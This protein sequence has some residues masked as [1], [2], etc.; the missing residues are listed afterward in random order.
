M[1]D[2]P[3]CPAGK[4]RD[5]GRLYLL[6]ILLLGAALRWHLALTGGQYFFNDEGRF[7]RGFQ[8]YMA[9]RS[10]NSSALR[11]AFNHADHTAFTA[12]STVT[13]AVQHLLAR[14]FTPWG[15][16]D[17][18]PEFYSFSIGYAA[19]VLSLAGVI[20]AW[21]VYQIAL[22]AGASQREALWACLLASVANT[23]VMYGR[24]L[25]GY[26][27][28]LVI[29]LWALLLVLGG[30]GFR[31]CLVAGVLVGLSYHVY[32][33]YW[34]FTPLLAAF[35]LLRGSNRSAGLREAA[36]FCFS[37]VA[38]IL[39]GYG[40]GC[41]LYGAEFL[42]FA[43]TFSGTV[44]QGVFAEG[45]S[46][47]WEFLTHAESYL[48]LAVLVVIV[49]AVVRQKVWRPEHRRARLWGG[50][51]LTSYLLLVIA[52]CGLHTFVVYARTVKPFIP[53]LALLGG[54]ALC[55][56][57]PRRWTWSAAAAILLLAA[58]NVAPHF[59][60]VFPREFE[61]AVMKAVG[62]PKRTLTVSGSLYIPVAQAVTAPRF[63][64]VNSQHLYPIRDAEPCPPGL[65]VAR[66]PHPLAYLPFQYE[67]HSPAMREFLRHADIDM[68]LLRLAD[69][70]RVPDD[71]PL[72]LRFQPTDRP[73]GFATLCSHHRLP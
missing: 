25:L 47:P 26:D 39:S 64:L 1:T 51:L 8:S 19:C 36:V 66:V 70:D 12:V 41:L 38:V 30:S 56:L 59:G 23:S 40:L 7:D 45:W 21:L 17:A 73:N 22:A 71:L 20:V 57:I 28:S 52:S 58:W 13:V 69:P 27:S 14:L 50:L 49:I 3:A 18:H 24:H 34:Y 33:G 60:R 4:P 6:L 65:I 46:F 44:Q 55:A 35:L 29:F 32:N 10:G 15:D 72:P 37:A 48:G 67:G 43:V 42:R 53:L 16:W 61:I 11:E 63:L 5:R 9:L 68:R 62:N 31:R 54:W 2:Q